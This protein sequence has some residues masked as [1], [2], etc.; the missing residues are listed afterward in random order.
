L[1]L[2]GLAGNRENLVDSLRFSARQGD[3][4]TVPRQAMPSPSKATQF[5]SLRCGNAPTSGTLLDLIRRYD[6]TVENHEKHRAFQRSIGQWPAKS[7]LF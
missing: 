7:L 2:T 6:E 5:K 4:R 1:Q 3:L